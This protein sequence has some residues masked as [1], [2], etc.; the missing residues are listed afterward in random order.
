MMKFIL[1]ISIPIVL[2]V[3]GIVGIGSKVF[4]API[5]IFCPHSVT[6]TTTHWKDCSSSADGSN[7]F[8]PPYNGENAV[9]VQYQFYAAS[10]GTHY[11]YCA[12]CIYKNNAGTDPAKRELV[13]MTNQNVL[14]SYRDYPDNFWKHGP[15]HFSDLCLAIHGPMGCP[16]RYR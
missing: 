7:F 5:A 1:N 9:I 16:W 15:R 14:T 4:A 3:G 13:L 10:T 6:C 12:L 8:N 2:F 11:P